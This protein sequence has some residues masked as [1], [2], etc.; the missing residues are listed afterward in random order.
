[1]EDVEVILDILNIGVEGI[2]DYQDVI[3]IAKI[4]YDLVLD[5]KVG[6]RGVLQVLEEEL[7]YKS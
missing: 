4:C 3:D 7:R 6:E 1:V 2:I 5:K